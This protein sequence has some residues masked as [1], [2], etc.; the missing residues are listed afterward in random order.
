MKWPVM[1]SDDLDSTISSNLENNLP[2]H[3]FMQNIYL[4]TQVSGQL[5][6]FIRFQSR[7]CVVQDKTAIDEKFSSE[8][9]TG[10]WGVS[11]PAWSGFGLDAAE[12]NA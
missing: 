11:K 4:F 2:S 3:L 1:W 8:D 7:I 12:Q 5:S 10:H 6:G 9:K